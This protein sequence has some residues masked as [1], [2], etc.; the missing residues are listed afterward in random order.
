MQHAAIHSISVLF[1]SSSFLV[2]CNAYMR[3]AAIHSISVLFFSSS[4]L[5]HLLLF[6]SSYVSLINRLPLQLSSKV[7]GEN[8]C[9]WDDSKSRGSCG[10]I[11]SQKWQ[12]C[13][14]TLPVKVMVCLSFITACIRIFYCAKNG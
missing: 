2:T 8:S 14:E 12:P 3:H 13:T 1:F 4:F 5:V 7:M 6:R 10:L 9:R 11:T